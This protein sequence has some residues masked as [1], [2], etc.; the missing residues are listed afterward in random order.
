MGDA[1]QIA[2]IAKYSLRDRYHSYFELASCR[3]NRILL[4]F[5]AFREGGRQALCIQHTVRFIEVN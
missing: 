5:A 3:Q 4:S 1:V 2:I